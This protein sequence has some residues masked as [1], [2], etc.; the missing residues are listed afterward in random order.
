[1]SLFDKPKFLFTA[2][3]PNLSAYIGQSVIIDG[4]KVKIQK[5]CGNKHKPQFYEV[6]GNKL[7]GMLRFHA[8]MLK[9]DS[10]TEEQFK[11]FEEIEFEVIQNK[12]D[13]N[14]MKDVP[15]VSQTGIERK[16]ETYN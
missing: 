5:I 10:I 4:K 16:T 12:N 7:I 3:E 15:N 8:Q 11:A 1:M 9:D 6:N 2:K 13:S 14:P